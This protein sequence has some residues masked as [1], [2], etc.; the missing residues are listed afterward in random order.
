MDL[1]SNFLPFNCYIAVATGHMVFLLFSSM[2]NKPEYVC[3]DDLSALS[4]IHG[5]QLKPE[6][7][8]D[9]TENSTSSCLSF[10]KVSFQKRDLRLSVSSCTLC[11]QL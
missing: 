5:T 6:P 7:M 9:G 1:K 8:E 4:D 11:V 2:A 10:C 3:S